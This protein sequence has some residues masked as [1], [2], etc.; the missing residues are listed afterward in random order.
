MPNNNIPQILIQSLKPALINGVAQKLPVL[1]RVQA[2]DAVETSEKKARKPYHLALA[3]DRSGSMSGRPLLEAVRCAR[4][5][6]DQLQP[7]RHR[8]ARRLR[9]SRANPRSGPSG[10]QPQGA[11]PGPVASP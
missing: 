11:A 8:L 4:H 6:A 10:R 1:I 5:I 2:P 3:I 7:H 9:R